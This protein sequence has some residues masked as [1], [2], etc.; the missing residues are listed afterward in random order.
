MKNKIKILILFKSPWDWNKFIINKLSKF[1]S[2]EYLYVNAI[3]GKNFSE[4]IL[5]IN[6]K[7][8]DNGI[9]IVFFE[10]D[11]YKFINL[12]FINKIENVKKVLMTFDDYDL[13][14]RNAITANACDLVVTG[15]PF[16]TKKYLEKGYQSLFMTL[17]ADGDI[18]KKHDEKK[19]RSIWRKS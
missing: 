11:Y 5:E 1:Y 12:F 13:H 10:V 17:E 6:N 18:F 7:I 2:V 16:I 19:D 8:K 9:E 15:C 4:T 14:D 3:Q